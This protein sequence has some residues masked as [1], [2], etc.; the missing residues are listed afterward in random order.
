MNT[1]GSY[2]CI[3]NDG[4]K[5]DSN[6]HSCIGKYNIVN[7]INT[8][9]FRCKVHYFNYVYW[10][11]IYYICG[12]GILDIFCHF[13]VFQILMSVQMIL[14]YVN[15]AVIIQMVVMYVTVNL[16]IRLIW[17]VSSVRVSSCKHIIS[18]YNLVVL[19]FCKHEDTFAFIN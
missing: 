19:F 16:G 2:E 10:S 14:N 11:I 8:V 5:L 7:F 9:G 6:L 1:D 3:C 13:F 17:V 18:S 12:F 4:Y 15:M